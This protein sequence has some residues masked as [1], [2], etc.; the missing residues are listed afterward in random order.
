MRTR[1]L[2]DGR[3]AYTMLEIMVATVLAGGAL[4]TLFG[5]FRTGFFILKH[6]AIETDAASI[7]EQVLAFCRA[8]VK[9]PAD[10]VIYLAETKLTV[11]AVLT[12]PYASTDT[13]IQGYGFPAP[14][15]ACAYVVTF[16]QADTTLGFS[17]GD[18]LADLSGSSDAA[19]IDAVRH[20]TVRVTVDV[21]WNDPAQGSGALRIR[22]VLVNTHGK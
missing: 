20:K 4:L 1:T 3:T 8:K 21:T 5:L 11:K 9:N 2:T 16:D 6:Q 22:T 17:D 15:P 18:A 7:G 10:G 14:P 12:N 13:T 19:L